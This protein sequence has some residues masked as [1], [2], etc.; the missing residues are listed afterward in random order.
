MFEKK[1]SYTLRVTVIVIV[2]IKF[3]YVIQWVQIRVY[4]MFE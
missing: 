3:K 4:I 1:N 2:K